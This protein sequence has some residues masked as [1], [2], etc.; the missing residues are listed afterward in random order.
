MRVGERERERGKRG[1]GGALIH[2]FKVLYKERKRGYRYMDLKTYI[3]R[4]R[5]I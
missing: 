5:G 1:G 4:E 3:R 2:G